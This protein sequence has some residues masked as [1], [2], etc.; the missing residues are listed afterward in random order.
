[1]KRLEEDSCFLRNLT[2][3]L[4]SGRGALRFPLRPSLGEGEICLYPLFP[5][6]FLSRNR[7]TLHEGRLSRSGAEPPPVP[8]LKRDRVL[9]G[10]YGVVGPEG[11]LLEREENQTACFAGLDRF[12]EVHFAR[13]RCDTL[14]LICYLDAFA[15]FWESYWG[16]EARPLRESYAAL[17]A[18][19]SSAAEE[20]EEPGPLPALMDALAAGDSLRLRTKAVEWLFRCGSPGGF[21]PSEEDSRENRHVRAAARV[22]AHLDAHFAASSTVRELARLQGTN[23]TYLERIFKHR[24]GTT[25]CGY[26]KTLRLARAEY[27]LVSSDLSVKEILFRVGYSDPGKFAGA[28]RARYGETPVAYRAR[29][30]QGFP[31]KL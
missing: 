5:G 24:Y 10:G 27:L 2:G 28:F 18:A 31:H 11:R 14:S 22:K 1:M 7:F 8:V 23:P 19:G 17:L 6:L 15:P 25:V 26:R 30:S 3:P 20:E 21:S 16:S 12:R 4:S 9:S 29:F 13:G